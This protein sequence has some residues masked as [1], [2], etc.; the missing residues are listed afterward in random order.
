MTQG[1]ASLRQAVGRS[2]GER[3][4]FSG[5]ASGSEHHHDV[6]ATDSQSRV[7][8]I[9]ENGPSQ[10]RSVSNPKSADEP[11]L[12]ALIRQRARHYSQRDSAVR[13]VTS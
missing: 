6:G 2:Q 10:P 7:Q 12:P 1:R 9:E 5:G 11:R 8:G 4:K 13:R 3:R